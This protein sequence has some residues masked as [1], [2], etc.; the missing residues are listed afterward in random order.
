MANRKYIRV[1]TGALNSETIYLSP[2]PSLQ[3]PPHDFCGAWDGRSE[4]ETV[5]V[6]EWWWWEGVVAT[7]EDR[8]ENGRK[9][10]KEREQQRDSL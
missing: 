4:E 7:G 2:T 3:F 8:G 10:G 6:L 1:P 5:R 9:R